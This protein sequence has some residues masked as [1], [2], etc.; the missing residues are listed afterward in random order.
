M[1]KKPTAPTGGPELTAPDDPLAFDDAVAHFRERVPMSDVEFD[2]LLEEEKKYAWKVSGVAQADIVNDVF[3]SLERAVAEGTSFDD[4]KADVEE[5][6]TS[7]WAGTVDDP[8]WRMETIFR[9][10]VQSAYG[11]GRFKQMSAPAVMQARPYWKFEAIEDDRTSDICE[12]AD[13]TVLAADDPFWASHNPP[14][15]FNCRSTVHALTPEEAKEEGVDD[16]APDTEPD[17]GFGEV[18]DDGA[19]FDAQTGDYPPEIRGELEDRLDEPSP[20]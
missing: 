6:L 3:Q 17:D 8:A 9:T 15:H 11:R 4:W 10:N 20:L 2:S 1:A 14:L 13:G 5:K 19:E 12:E 18:P 7:A 16:E